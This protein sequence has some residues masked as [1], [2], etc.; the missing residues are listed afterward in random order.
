LPWSQAKA[1]VV[2]NLAF[3]NI[4]LEKLFGHLLL[5]D[6]LP[7]YFQDLQKMKTN[8]NLVNSFKSSLTSHLVG[9]K[10]SKI[11]MAKD[12]IIPWPPPN[13]SKVLERWERC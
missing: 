6:V 4:V 10:F 5:K 2:T 12:I 13:L 9:A 7:P 11:T 1:R 8:Q 3:K